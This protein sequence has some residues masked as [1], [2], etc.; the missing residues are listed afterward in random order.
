[1]SNI[2]KTNNQIE[3]G[4]EERALLTGDLAALNQE[5]RTSLYMKVC[6]SLNLNP[7]TQPFQ[8]LNLNGKLQMYASRNCTDQLRQIHSV[9]LKIT[10]RTTVG[11]AYIVTAQ[12]STPAGRVDESTGVIVAGHLKGDNLANALM[13]A[14]TKAK[15]RVTLSI[16]GL[17]MMDETEL[18]TVKD[19]KLVDQ[20]MIC[21]P[22]VPPKQTPPPKPPA[23][24]QEPPMPTEPPQQHP[25]DDGPTFD[26]DDRSLELI[27]KD[28]TE[29]LE[30]WKFPAGRH[31]GKTLF[32]LGFHN[33]KT[34]ANWVLD[35]EFSTGK[36][37]EG[38]MKAAIEM[39]E[40]YEK[41][42]QVKK[43]IEDRP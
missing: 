27:E 7:L 38:Y 17:S 4:P 30:K 5:Q 11:D 14:E 12:A 9:S 40:V 1:M 2:V 37:P 6:E 41:W 43:Q 25:P 22:V 26:D 20:A 28:L 35:Q 32:E 15:R 23:K 13:K 36:K 33:S 39:F 10:G 42:H 34:Y 21:A 3:I 29:Q 24:E 19:A 8:Y 31:A 16:C 18:E